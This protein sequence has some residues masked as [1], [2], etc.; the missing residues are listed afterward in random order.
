MP[1]RCDLLVAGIILW[2]R[3]YAVRIRDL[4]RGAYRMYAVVRVRRRVEA[5]PE[6]DDGNG[7]RAR[8]LVGR[9][10]RNSIIE[11]DNA[12]STFNA[13]AWT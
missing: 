1:L 5:G 2:E 6:V 9:P 4:I 3:Q 13:S 12:C 8:R 10:G 11:C 7:R